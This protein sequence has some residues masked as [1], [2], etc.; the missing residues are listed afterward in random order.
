MCGQRRRRPPSRRRSSCPRSSGPRSCRPWRTP[1]RTAARAAAQGGSSDNEAASS[2]SPSTPFPL[3]RPLPRPPPRPRALYARASR[4]AMISSGRRRWRSEWQ[5]RHMGRS[6]SEVPVVHSGG[7][8]SILSSVWLKVAC[9]GDCAVCGGRIRSIGQCAGPFAFLR[10]GDTA[11]RLSCAS[12]ERN[13]GS[14]KHAQHII[15]EF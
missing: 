12:G 2:S 9:G 6:S 14:I 10:G 4:C 11:T 3:T 13:G 15:C 1:F 5:T 8:S 7:G